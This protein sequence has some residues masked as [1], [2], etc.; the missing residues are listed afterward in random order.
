LLAR[1][2][3]DLTRKGVRFVWTMEHDEAMHLLK[4][5][6]TSP[7]A[8]RPID[9]QS[10]NPVIVAVDTS[11]RAVGYILLQI[12]DQGCRR[13]ARYGS[14]ALNDVESHYSQAKLELYGLFRALQRLRQYIANVK[15]LVVEVDAKYI[16]GMLNHPDLQPSA[17]INRWIFGIL[18]FQFDLVHVPAKDHQ[19]ADGLSRR[20]VAEEDEEEKEEEAKDDEWMEYAIDAYAYLQSLPKWSC[21]EVR[22]MSGAKKEKPKGDIDAKEDELK[23]IF[24]FL[25]YTRRPDG[26][27]DEEFKRFYRKATR[28]F[29]VNDH[30]WKRH[31]AGRHQQVLFGDQQRRALDEMHRQIGHRGIQATYLSITERFW[32]PNI[33]Q[34]VVDFVRSCHQCQVHST[35][36]V[37]LPVTVSEPYGLWRKVYLD[38]MVM[39][40]AHGYRYIIVARDDLTRYPEGRNLRNLTSKAVATFIWED[41]LC[42]HGAVEEIVTD[43]GPE[44][45]GAV[46]E[47]CLRY[48][49]HHIRISPYNSQANGVV[50]NGHFILR[51]S[52]IKACDGDTGH[53]P[54]LTHHA[55]WADRITIRQSTGFSPFYLNKG[56]E[57]VLPFDLIEATYLGPALDS[58]ISTTD[59]L[60]H[61]IRQLEK[62]EDDLRLAEKRLLKSRF[63]SKEQFEKH[64]QHRLH[65]FDFKPGSLVLVRNSR[66]EAE[67][68]RKV[69]PRY[70]GPFIV[71]RRN[72]RGSY[73]LA[74]LDGSISKRSYAAFRLIP[75]YRRRDISIPLD[76]LDADESAESMD[77]GPTSLLP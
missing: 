53:W 59:L 46:D 60:A 8:L 15:K 25:R 20:P 5:A 66:V 2:L 9:Y 23:K 68:D 64:F 34:S 39:P 37:S 17:T 47:L 32:W 65:D 26:M 61:R 54:Y 38:A 69:K 1:P 6:V 35:Q 4:E 10:W 30:L 73:T 70:L 51:Q 29:H 36:K 40:K 62:R 72:K 18:L 57:P 58:I 48:K 43:N 56:V 33:Y 3:R 12:D 77:E 16:K 74:E 7:P 45:K 21:G 63:Q 75:Y 14:V 67:L 11:S 44:V 52:I 19:A 42:R 50:E 31:P 41:I 28:F 27:T 55:L 24:D 49:I 13:P 76:H 71:I 22:V